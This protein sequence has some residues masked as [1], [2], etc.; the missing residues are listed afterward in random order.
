MRDAASAPSTRSSELIV[1]SDELESF[2]DERFPVVTV[3]C[4]DGDPFRHQAPVTP[5]IEAPGGAGGEEL[6]HAVAR[7]FHDELA[8]TQHREDLIADSETG[9]GAEPGALLDIRLAEETRGDTLKEPCRGV[10]GFG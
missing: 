9:H 10:T 2:D 5:W 6:V 3:L 8:A 4:R 1:G 7:K